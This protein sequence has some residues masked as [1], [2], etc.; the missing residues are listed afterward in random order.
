MAAAVGLMV[1]LKLNFVKY[2]AITFALGAVTLSIA[3]IASNQWLRVTDNSGAKIFQAGLFHAC[4]DVTQDGVDLGE[5]CCLM[6]QN[7]LCNKYNGLVNMFS[8]ATHHLAEDKTCGQWRST[9]AAQAFAI[10]HIV[11]IAIALLALFSFK[12]N[13]DNMKKVA[14]GSSALAVACGVI[15][16]AISIGLKND[17]HKA[18]DQGAAPGDAV[19]RN[20]IINFTAAWICSLFA[21]LIT[22]AVKKPSLGDKLVQGAADAVAS[23]V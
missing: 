19:Y 5:N 7:S 21:F 9:V 8:G 22:I 4:S 11:L 6:T 3:G 1:N 23:T 12:H 16:M 2:V 20:G 15:G 10:S 13:F 18:V 17:F 14:L